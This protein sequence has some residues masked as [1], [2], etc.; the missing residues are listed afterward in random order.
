MNTDQILGSYKG[1]GITGVHFLTAH[2]ANLAIDGDIAFL[3]LIFC[4]TAG[5]DDVGILHGI[6]ELDELGLDAYGNFIGGILLFDVNF[7][8]YSFIK[9]Q[10]LTKK[11]DAPTHRRRRSLPPGV[12]LRAANQ[13]DGDCRWQSHYNQL[14]GRA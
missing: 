3:N 9:T 14:G 7:H 4:L 6:L 12:V 1:E 10:N 5:V 8:N 2:G 13:N 11:D